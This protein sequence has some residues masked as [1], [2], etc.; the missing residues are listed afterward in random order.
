M[1]YATHNCIGPP[2]YGKSI[3]STLVIEDLGPKQT[4]Y[5]HFIIHHLNGASSDQ[6]FRALATQLVHLYRHERATLDALS[7]LMRKASSQEKACSED[8]ISVLCLLLRQHPTFLVI[9]GIDHCDDIQTLLTTLPDL[10]S[11][12]DARIIMFSRPGINIPIPYQKWESNYPHII[13]L[14]SQQICSDIEAYLAHNFDHMA[15]QGYF[16]E[17]SINGSHINQ[18]AARSDGVFLWASLLIKYL[19]SPQLSPAERRTTLEQAHQLKGLGPLYRLILVVLERR[20]EIELKVVAELF[21]WLASSLNPLCTSQLRTVLAMASGQSGNE[22]QTTP[23]WEDWIPQIT[24]GLVEVTENR[25]IFTH[26]TVKEYLRSFHSRESPFTLYDEG[27]VQGHLAASCLSYLTNE[28]PQKPLQIPQPPVR[29]PGPIHTPSSGLSTRTG[30]SSDSGYKS[31][32]SASDTEMVTEVP[33]QDIPAFDA[34]MPFLRYATLVW[35]IHL[36]R[37][38]SVALSQPR[39]TNEQSMESFSSVPWLPALSHFLICRPAVTTWVEAS[40]L[41]SLPPNL[42]RLIPLLL[43]VKARMPLKDCEARELDGVIQAFRRLNDALAELKEKHGTTL[44]LYPSLIWQRNTPSSTEGA[45]W[46]V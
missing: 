44:T 25:A 9:D 45:F 38:L 12:S 4:I 28:V 19:Q 7:L 42:S 35:P 34:N 10:C 22:D 39:P 11:V 23:N 20:S 43:N 31:V 26:M 24:C 13:S 30:S 3:L 15:S 18:I 41:Y 46:A 5:F 29:S 27:L 36:T 1:T 33:Q 14:T 8:V 6:A 16:G 32:S 21:R 2:G 40:W 17:V 37:A